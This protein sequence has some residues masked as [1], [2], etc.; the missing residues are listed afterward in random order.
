MDEVYHVK[1]STNQELYKVHVFFEAFFKFSIAPEKRNWKVNPIKEKA[2]E[3]NKSVGDNICLIPGI[4][5][6]PSVLSF[7]EPLSCLSARTT[8]V[9]FHV[10]RTLKVRGGS[11]KLVGLLEVVP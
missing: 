6:P 3:A 1:V 2:Q 8:T 10:G 5:P 9:F 11:L 4:K 7:V